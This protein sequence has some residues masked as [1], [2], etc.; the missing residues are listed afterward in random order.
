MG[1][2]MRMGPAYFPTV[3]GALLAL[4]GLAVMLR[5]LVQDGEPAGKLAWGKIALVLGANA[6][7]GLLLRRM[8]LV[9]S[10]VLFVLVSASASRR[11]GLP[12]G[13]ALAVGLAAFCAVAFVKLLGLA[14][15]LLGPW[16][17]G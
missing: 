15:P 13:L 10:L 14:I 1:T 11:F 9:V 6:I 3:L 12:A 5:A 7:F 4:I 2:A 8:G 17:G 16:L